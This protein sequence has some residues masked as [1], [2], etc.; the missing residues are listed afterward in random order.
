MASSLRLE[1]RDRLYH[2]CPEDKLHTH[3]VREETDTER[4]IESVV[5]TSSTKNFESAIFAKSQQ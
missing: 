3:T 2:E 5:S 1:S 4:Y